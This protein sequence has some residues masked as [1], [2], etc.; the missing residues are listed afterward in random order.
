[1]TFLDIEPAREEG[2]NMKNTSA[3]DV[4]VLCLVVAK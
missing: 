4:G 3:M 1:V 2:M